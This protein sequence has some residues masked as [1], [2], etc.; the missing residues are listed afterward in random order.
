ME[1]DLARHEVHDGGTSLFTVD[2]DSLLF[3]GLGIILN[4]EDDGR[5]VEVLRSLALNL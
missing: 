3:S 5:D 2:T 4:G 1:G